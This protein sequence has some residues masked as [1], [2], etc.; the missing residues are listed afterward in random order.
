MNVGIDSHSAEREGEGN[1]TYCRG[2]I[3]A[4]VGASDSNDLTMFAADP[5]HA[6]YRSLEA[7]PPRLVRVTQ[8]GGV[9]RLAF[10]LGRAATRA[11]VASDASLPAPSLA[12]ASATSGVVSVAGSGV[13]RTGG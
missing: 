3:S 7:R 13:S 4:L 8:G 2:L 12:A 1:A 5:G 6:F 9:A 11:G 10:A